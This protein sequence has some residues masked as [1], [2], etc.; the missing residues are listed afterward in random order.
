MLPSLW[1][2]LDRPRLG[3]LVG[4]VE[5]LL[6][7]RQGRKEVLGSYPTDT[8]AL[9][10]ATDG[11]YALRIGPGHWKTFLDRTEL[12]KLRDALAQLLA[13]SNPGGPKGER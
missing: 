12:Q 9:N 11:G 10:N 7:G 13:E 2:L 3:D 1:V 5:Q 6:A 4:V 8:I